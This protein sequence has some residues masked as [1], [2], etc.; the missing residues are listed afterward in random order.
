MYVRNEGYY[1]KLEAPK[2]F[3]FAFP[4]HVHELVSYFTSLEDR[5]SEQLPTLVDMANVE[6][7]SPDAIMYLLALMDVYSQ[8][9]KMYVR[10]HAPRNKQA[11][12]LLLESGF[13]KFVQSR[14]PFD[15]KQTD[16]LSI[17]SGEKTD[18]PLVKR[19]V[20]FSNERL[21]KDYDKESQELYSVIMEI[22]GNTKQH[23]YGE[24]LPYKPKWW[25]AAVHYKDILH[26]GKDEGFE[27][28]C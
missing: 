23:A 22:I 13:Y 18:G 27:G 9:G 11:L 19:V 10:G 3:S 8:Q 12:T 24:S 25:I 4:Q 20:V 7:I 2:V 17:Q 6:E 1:K 26:A 5:L 21:Q 14:V 28:I 16:I 15:D